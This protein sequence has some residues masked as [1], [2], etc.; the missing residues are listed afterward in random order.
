MKTQSSSFRAICGNLTAGVFNSEVLTHHYHPTC[1]SLSKQLDKEN[2]Q[3]KLSVFVD[4]VILCI[5]NQE[6][7]SIAS[8]VT[9]Q[10]N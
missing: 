8:K 5:E 2:K 1:K 3:K 9:G 4:G 7:A 6:V 10:K